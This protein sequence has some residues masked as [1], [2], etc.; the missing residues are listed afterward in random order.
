MKITKIINTSPAIFI[1]GASLVGCNSDNGDNSTPTNDDAGTQNVETGVFLDSP[2]SGLHYETDTLSGETNAE[3][4]FHYAQGETV[5]FSIGGIMFGQAKGNSVITPLDLVPEAKNDMSHPTVINMVRF[6]LTFDSDGEP[7]N[8][9]HIGSTIRDAARDH[10]FHFDVPV[11]E[12]ESNSEMLNFI[13]QMTNISDMVNTNIAMAHFQETLDQMAPDNMEGI[14]TGT[15]LDGPVS[16]LHYETDTLSGNTNAEGQFHYM[17]GESVNFG[18][19]NM[20]FGHAMGNSVI[21]PMD[22]VPD[23]NEVSHPTVTNMVRFMLT[24]DSDGDPN[25]GIHIDNA[26]RFAAYG[27]SFNFDMPMSAFE[28]NPDVLDF[29][30]QMPHTSHM[31][32][33]G[34]AQE[35][36]QGTLDDMGSG[37]MDDENMGMNH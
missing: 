3:G 8:G 34:T 33:T 12:F 6:M 37:M 9:I 29:I 27:R 36:F 17:E 23:A 31:V 13:G 19:G 22:L 10:S 14:M 4:Q 7:K 20:M 28:S 1:L 18:I 35:H 21:T 32:S 11:S 24:L 26:M 2:V 30:N 25:N 5:T 15:F 16:G